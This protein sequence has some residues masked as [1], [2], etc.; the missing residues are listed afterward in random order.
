[1]LIY[2]SIGQ[3]ETPLKSSSFTAFLDYIELL[4]KCLTYDVKEICYRYN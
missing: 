2:I 4:E 3:T 1:M